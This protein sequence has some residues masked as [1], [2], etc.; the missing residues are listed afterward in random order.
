[1]PRLILTTVLLLCCVCSLPAQPLMPL[2]DCNRNGI[3]D[4]VDIVYG[5]SSDVDRNGIP[6]E[7]E[8]PKQDPYTLR[9]PF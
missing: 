2:A 5:S 1:M 3:E 8:P 6:D 4:S 9:A 7:C